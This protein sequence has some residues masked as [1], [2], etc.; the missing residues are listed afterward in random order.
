M[1]GLMVLFYVALM[2]LFYVAGL[3]QS[4]HTEG[5]PN[6]KAQWFVS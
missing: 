3:E 5:I 1:V 6:N 2:V 4:L